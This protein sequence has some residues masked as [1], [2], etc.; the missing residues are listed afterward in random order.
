MMSFMD[1][2]RRRSSCECY[3]AAILQVT[4]LLMFQL[5]S[6]ILHFRFLLLLF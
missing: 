2:A 5:V 4:Q 6:F 3:N 1:S